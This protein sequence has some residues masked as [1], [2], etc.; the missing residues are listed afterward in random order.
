MIGARNYQLGG[1]ARMGPAYF[2]TMLGGLMA[3]MGAVV[4]FRSLVVKGGKVTAIPLRLLSIITFSIIV[5]GYLLRPIGLVPGPGVSGGRFRIP[6]KSSRSRRCS[7]FPV[8]WS[9]Y[10]CWSL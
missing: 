10:P 6:G 5:F 9:S 4:F 7:F 3:L 8:C 1:A 2:P